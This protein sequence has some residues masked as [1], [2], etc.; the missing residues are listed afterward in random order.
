MIRC[1]RLVQAQGLAC[2]D[3]GAPFSESGTARALS[4]SR[5]PLTLQRVRA[6]EY[7]SRALPS[8]N[9]CVCMSVVCVCMCMSVCVRRTGTGRLV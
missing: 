6:S 9:L 7:V 2:C 4:L 5:D 3:R 8:S 1:E